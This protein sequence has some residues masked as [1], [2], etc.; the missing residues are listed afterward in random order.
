MFV[1]LFV[2]S[3]GGYVGGGVLYNHRTKGIPIG[4]QALPHM[5]FWAEIGHLVVDGV[6]FAKAVGKG[7]GSTKSSQESAVA[8][9]S[10]GDQVR[11]EALIE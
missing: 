2:L 4:K 11:E 9:R 8:K 6:E 1:A 3:V 10:A 5:E 7:S